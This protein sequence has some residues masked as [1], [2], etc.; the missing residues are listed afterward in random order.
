M[1]DLTITPMYFHETNGQVDQIKE[2]INPNANASQFNE[3]KS[4]NQ[5]KNV[6]RVQIKSFASCITI[7]EM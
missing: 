7:S 4:H 3:T 2:H 1:K 5:S 6:Q